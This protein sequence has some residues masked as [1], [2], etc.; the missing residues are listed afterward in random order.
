MGYLA[1]ASTA[2]AFADLKMTRLLHTSKINERIDGKN[3]LGAN[4]TSLTILPAAVVDK[5]E[6]VKNININSQP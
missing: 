1:S 3:T 5:T 2:F 6:K 4:I